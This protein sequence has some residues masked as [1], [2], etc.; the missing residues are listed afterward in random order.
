MNNPKKF[1][2]LVETNSDED[3]VF[4]AVNEAA[5]LFQDVGVRVAGGWVRDKLMGRASGS[6]IDM[7]VTGMPADEFAKVVAKR[8]GVG[9]HTIRENPDKSKHV[10]TARLNLRTP[11]ISLDFAMARSERYADDSRIPFVSAGTPEEDAMRRDFTVNALFWRVP[12]GP[13]EDF[14]GG[15]DDLRE[16][17]LRSPIAPEKM[18]MDDPLR[19]LRAARF[20]AKLGFWIETELYRAMG[21]PDVVSALRAKVSKERIGE[22]LVKIASCPLPNMSFN[23]LREV[24]V[25]DAIL[26]DALEGG[27]VGKLAPLDMGQGVPGRHGLNLWAHSIET[28]AAASRMSDGNPEVV[29]AAL[30]HDFGKAAPGVRVD[31]DE[32]SSYIGHER[33]SADIVRLFMNHVKAGGN[34]RAERIASM[35]RLHMRPHFLHSSG[36]AGMR[37]FVRRCCEEDVSW[38]DVFLL[39]EADFV[40]RGDVDNGPNLFSQTRTRIEIAEAAVQR[41]RFGRPKPILDG[42]E[43]MDILGIVPGP[44]MSNLVMVLSD[45]QDQDPCLSKDEAAERFRTGFAD[46][47]REHA[48]A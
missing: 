23:I 30:F 5:C 47:T 28:A 35:V 3:S 44:W 15:M 34:G 9:E 12:N 27:S 18:F 42:N 40:S 45:W 2:G 1:E 38:K 29:L 17:V 7:T 43:I 32:K 22:E 46:V 14:C 10:R 16:K 36:L 26:S 11:P 21:R 20:A 4:R 25:F 37:R 39:S 19:V 41:D 6:D 24:G 13:V 31:G 48:R 33:P 8:L